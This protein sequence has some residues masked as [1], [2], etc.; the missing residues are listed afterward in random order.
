M[1]DENVNQELSLDDIFSRLRKGDS[2]KR[3]KDR[4]PFKFLDSYTR[5]DSNIFFG[6]DNETEDIFRKLYSGK[7]LLVYGKSGTG[8][9][10]IINCGL[11][12]RIPLEDIYAI[13]IRCGNKAYDNFI[14][15]IS[16][17]SEQK[18]NDPLGILEDIFY[19]RSK[20]VALI[21]DQFEEVFILS[22]EEEKEKLAKS[23]NL[24]LKSRLKINIILVIRE[25][26]FASLTDF[27][28]FIPRLYDNRVRIERM[29]R[30]SAREA[31]VSPCMACNVGIEEG[32]AD[33][34]IEQ[35]ISQSEGLE[36]TWLQILM[37]KLYRTAAERDLENPLIKNEDLDSLGRIGNVLSNFLD[38][39]LRSM[40]H[41]DLG[42]A[43]LKAMISSDGTKKQVD[44]NEISETIQTSGFTPD[45]ILIEEILRH[46]INVRII[47]EKDDQGFFELRHDALAGRIFERMTGT[48]REMIEV[49]TF[50][51]N[52]YRTFQQRKILLSDDDLKYISFYETKL[53]LRDEIKEFIRISKKEVLRSR[54]R[55]RNIAVSSAAALI[56]ILTFFTVWAM[57][58]RGKAVEQTVVA[59]KQKNEAIQANKEAEESRMLA[60]EGEKNKDKQR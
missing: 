38:E 30:S 60:L 40:P 53:I 57:S 4:A 18:Q 46:L 31:I 10:S 39:Q 5:D 2:E 12:S 9:S 42:E 8:K 20:P 34:V 51:D 3:K 14:S 59:E 22:D 28:P 21:F 25:E 49:R 27:E 44:I 55:R 11:I 19:T 47:T 37:D 16:K 1:P 45:H 58:E 15:E 48:E 50:L 33:R 36:L 26:Y 6:R 43:V 56:F 29:S 52:S 35:L 41:G 13:N 24:I 54:Q 17:H 32:L 23:L 7:L